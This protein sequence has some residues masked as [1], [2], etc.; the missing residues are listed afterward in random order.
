MVLFGKNPFLFAVS[1]SLIWT[2]SLECHLKS[3]PKH[4]SCQMGS[5]KWWKVISW[6]APFFFLTVLCDPHC[7]NCKSWSPSLLIIALCTYLQVCQGA[8][9]DP[10]EADRAQYRGERGRGAVDEEA[11]APLHLS[12]SIGLLE[13]LQGMATSF[14]QRE[15][16]QEREPRW[17]L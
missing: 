2:K 1:A 6:F 7:D 15:P 10:W 16:F 8:Q 4:K 11:S 17:K 13:R 5:K 12:S 3:C 9:W 14:P